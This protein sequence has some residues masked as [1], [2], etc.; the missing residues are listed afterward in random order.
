[1]QAGNSIGKSSIVSIVAAAC[2]ILGAASARAA[3]YY[4][5]HSSGND[6]WTGRAASPAGT[7]E[8]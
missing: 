1:M 4:V 5:S 8:A 6:S 2:L 3:T 7:A